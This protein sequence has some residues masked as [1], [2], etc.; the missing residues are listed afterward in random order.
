M[1]LLNLAKIR[2][3]QDRIEQVYRP[4]QFEADEDFRVVAH[5]GGQSIAQLLCDLSVRMYH[6]YTHALP[7]RSRASN[8]RSRFEQ[9]R[10][11]A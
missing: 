5:F 2:T 7:D 9:A 8:I 10:L 3:A 6:R 4:E 1:L 11:A